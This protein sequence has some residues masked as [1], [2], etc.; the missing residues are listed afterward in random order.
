[1][2]NALSRPD[3]WILRYIRIYRYIALLCFALLCFA[4][5]CF[6]LLCFALLCFALLCFA[7]LCFA[8]LC[9]ALLCFALTAD[10][11]VAVRLCMLYQFI[12]T[13]MLLPSSVIISSSI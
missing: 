4:L 7:L 8:L 6:A 10:L 3:D 13:C 9:F 12:S 1:M 2:S 5:L 11:T